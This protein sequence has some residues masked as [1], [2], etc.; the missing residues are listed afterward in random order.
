MRTRAKAGRFA[1]VARRDGGAAAE[2]ALLA[3]AV[4]AD[5]AALICGSS[6]SFTPIT[7]PSLASSC[8]RA[9]HSQWPGSKLW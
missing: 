7:L 4:A 1:W 8:S 3:Q 6:L 5:S 9:E 2:A